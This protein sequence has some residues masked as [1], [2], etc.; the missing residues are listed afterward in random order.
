MKKLL[1]IESSP[2]GNESSSTNLARKLIGDLL[3]R[4]ST[5]QVDHMDLWTEELPPMS[6]PTVSAKYAVFS[7]EP[8]SAE[9]DK[10]WSAV[11]NC[12]DRFCAADLV[13][14]AVPMWNF[15]IPY[16]LKHFV[17][18]VTQPRLTFTWTPQDGY[19]TLLPPRR[20]IIISSSAGD[21]SV[22]SGNEHN[23]FQLRYLTA[24]LKIYMG[25]QVD[26]ISVSPTIA[27]PDTVKAAALA[28]RR[29]A[30]ELV[31]GI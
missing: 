3:E 11:V 13:L 2:R 23:D 18:V 31:R 30:E 22:G 6:G 20:A 17:D 9:Q 19:K 4:D 16:V 12:I 8:L 5:W 14:M 15:G 27:D 10:A 28:A 24:W 25:C 21:Y 29:R 7:G 1:F 26:S